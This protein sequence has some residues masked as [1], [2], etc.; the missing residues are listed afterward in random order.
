VRTARKAAGVLPSYK[1]VDTCAAEFEAA[2]PYLYSS[3]DGSCEAAPSASKKVRCL[4][5]LTSS[6][7]MAGA[8]TPLQDPILIPCL[9]RGDVLL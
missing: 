6:V 1:R 3:Y 2:T 4:S 9:Q 5:R 7:A 8:C